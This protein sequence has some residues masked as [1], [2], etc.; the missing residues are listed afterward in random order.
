MSHCFNN[1]CV[2]FSATL[3]YD[4]QAST[5][6]VGPGFDMYSRAEQE[7]AKKGIKQNVMLANFL[8]QKN[9]PVAKDLLG[10]TQFSFFVPPKCALRDLDDVNATTRLPVP[11]HYKPKKRD[12]LFAVVYQNL[13]RVELV[14]TTDKLNT[15]ISQIN[16]HGTP[17]DRRMPTHQS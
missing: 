10:K 16:R 17:G 7:L 6:S 1:R 5:R 12:L 9:S 11:S 2:V 4:Y 15:L 3:Q 13:A 14:V 8:R